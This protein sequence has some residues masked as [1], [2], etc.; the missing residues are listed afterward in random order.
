MHPEKFEGY[1][2][3]E[4]LLADRVILITGAGDG[5]GAAL[6]EGAADLGARV[7]LLGR[8]QKKLEA[9]ND[10]IVAA[11][12]AQPGIF[13]MDLERAGPEYYQM[14]ADALGENYG[15]LDGLVHNAALLGD[16]SPIEHYDVETWHRVMHVN[17]TAQFILTRTVFP[18]LRSSSDASVIFASSGVGRVG[19]PYWGAYA[20]SKFGTEGLMQVLASEVSSST[21]IRVNAVNPGATRTAMRRAAYPGEDPETLPAPADV[22]PAYFFLLGPDGAAVNGRTIDAQP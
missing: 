10:R 21:N 22:L 1:Q 14:L 4:N 18:L 5:I 2:P 16:R 3:T 17:L 11:G 6:A 13:V 19:R 20:V 12:R 15:R 9:V 7:V 8:T